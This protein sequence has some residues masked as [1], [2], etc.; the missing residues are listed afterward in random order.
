M[1]RTHNRW[2][3]PNEEVV[4]TIHRPGRATQPHSVRVTSLVSTTLSPTLVISTG[5]GAFDAAVERPP[6]LP[7]QLLVLFKHS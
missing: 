6:H 3:Q 4:I 7:L 2:L 5:G 1:G